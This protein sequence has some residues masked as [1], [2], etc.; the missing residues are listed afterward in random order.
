MK[1]DAIDFSKEFQEELD[2]YSGLGGI[3]MSRLGRLVLLA[4]ANGAGKT[5]LF[6]L[7]CNAN[8]ENHHQ[9][10]VGRKNKQVA[11]SQIDI[12]NRQI[13][14]MPQNPQQEN[15]EKA[16]A[17]YEKSLRIFS[18]IQ[19]ENDTEFV[20]V[21]YETKKIELKNASQLSLKVHQNYY[22][23]VKT[24]GTQG[25]NEQISS[26]THVVISRAN[27][28]SSTRG[29]IDEE[30]K[31]KAFEEEGHLIE[32]LTLLLGDKS[33]FSI[34]AEENL[35]IFNR[36][37]YEI[38]LSEGQ[39]VLFQLGCA[40][41]AQGTKLSDAIIFFDEPENHL[42]PAALIEVISRLSE[43]TV[44][45]Q[46]WIATH[47]VPLIAHLAKKDPNCLWYMEN[48]SVQHAG[49]K[50]ELVLQGLMGGQA[51]VQALQDFTLLPSQLAI[52]RF[53]AE[54]LNP[55]TTVPASEN[56]P[57]TS[58][59]TRKIQ[60]LRND[61]E[62]GA[63]LRVLDYGAGKG[64]LLD[65]LQATDSGVD[66][67]TWLDYRAYDPFE[68][69]KTSC[70]ETIC[71]TYDTADRR[72]FNTLTGVNSLNTATD[73]AS[74]DLI[75]M[76]NVLHEINPDEWLNCFGNTSKSRLT[77][78]LKP[79]GGLLVVEDYQIPT[80]ELA[81]KHGFLLLDESELKA[82]FAWKEA[83]IGNFI[84]DSEQ[85]HR[86]KDRLVMHWIAQ[87]LL[88]R[89]TDETRRKAITTLKDNAND[90]IDRLQ[91]KSV[92]TE[93]FSRGHQ[94]ALASQTFTNAARWIEKN[95]KSTL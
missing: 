85:D 54:C 26:Y 30:K 88:E 63:K 21:I 66:L 93:T 58:A 13:L 43:L 38:S 65:A 8:Q 47:S 52:N 56:D 19:T 75:V 80:G 49:R 34:T 39:K 76:C 11:I 77:K 81:H 3:K 79:N 1:I 69:D 5:R 45:G 83:D 67:K 94:I 64:R 33:K 16:I 59:I 28:A 41:H 36:E 74:Y 72:Y 17:T 4:G 86:Y 25:L 50:P 32:I 35:S 51:G 20:P 40:L 29:T 73:D 22:D 78:L 23:A 91:N 6:Q 10:R 87:P 60:T 71:R 42:H 9:G 55:P 14:Q 84:R 92:I 62:P 48:G 2:H 53:L 27:R 90:A 89:V 31:S 57:Q 7:I 46:L 15:W 12:L 61:L 82:L 24:P 70:I 68:D 44:D 18:A 95:P 37:D